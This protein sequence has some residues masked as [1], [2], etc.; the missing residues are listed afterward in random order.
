M[1]RLELGVHLVGDVHVGVPQVRRDLLH[2]DVLLAHL[3]RCRMMQVVYREVL[4]ASPCT[5]PL[6]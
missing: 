3:D 4:D 2:P 1:L 6:G 5:G